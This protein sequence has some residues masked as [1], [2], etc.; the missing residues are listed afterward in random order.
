V[1]P[2]REATLSQ[3]FKNIY[4]FSFIYIV[5]TPP[6]KRPIYYITTQGNT[7]L[8][9]APLLGISP[10]LK[11]LLHLCNNKRLLGGWLAEW[12]SF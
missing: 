8:F 5:R 7:I 2:S 10:E 11:F 4:V 3:L 12:I 6:W 9:I 1:P